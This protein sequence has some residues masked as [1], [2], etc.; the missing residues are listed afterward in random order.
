MTVQL[1]APTSETLQPFGQAIASQQ[2]MIQNPTRVRFILRIG[3]IKDA[4]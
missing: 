4:L 2:I 3:A 1:T